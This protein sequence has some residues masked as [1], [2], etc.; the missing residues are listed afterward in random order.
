A[1]LMYLL[2]ALFIVWSTDK[3]AYF[4]GNAIGKHKLAPNVS[5]NK[6][7]EGFIGGIVCALVIGGGFYYFAELPVN[8]ALVLALLVFLSIFGQL[9]DFVESALKRFYG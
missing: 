5:P 6:T 8:I 2:F 3:G 9:G 1:G 4:I 7:V